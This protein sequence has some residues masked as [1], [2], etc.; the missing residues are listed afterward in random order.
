LRQRFEDPGLS[1]RERSFLAAIR[2]PFEDLPVDEQRLFIGG[3]A[4]LLDDVRADE[5]AAYRRLLELLEE[6]AAL[7][8]LLR[9]AFEPG[10][11]FIRV[12]QELDVAALEDAALVGAAYGT[13]NRALGAVSLLG[14][15]RMDYEKAVRAVRAVAQELSRVA[16][17][18]YA[19]A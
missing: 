12:G 11:P 17:D 4:G 7:L 19:D 18:V 16:D 6:R 2:P 9:E 3:A 14:P 13:I 1:S 5:L 10:R 15:A 8:A